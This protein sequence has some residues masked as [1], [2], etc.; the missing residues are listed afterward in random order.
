MPLELSDLE[1]EVLTR[2]W[3]E[4]IALLT[5]AERGKQILN[6]LLTIIAGDGAT[7]GSSS[8]GI[9]VLAAPNAE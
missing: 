6:D 7:I 2:R 1:R 4:Y 8:R 3:D 5:Q 9:V